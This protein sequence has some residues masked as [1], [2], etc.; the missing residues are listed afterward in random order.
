M[1]RLSPTFSMSLL[2]V[3]TVKPTKTPGLGTEGP[4]AVPVETP[5]MTKLTILL[6]PG[7]TTND[8]TEE[9]LSLCSS[10]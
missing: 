8:L 2:V 10:L 3:R 4:I 5:I 7:R 9:I 6:R 1:D